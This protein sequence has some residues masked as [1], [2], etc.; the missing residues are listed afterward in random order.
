[1]KI[2]MISNSVRLRLRKSDLAELEQTRLIEDKVHFPGNHHFVFALS[3]SEDDYI[4]A[5]YNKERLLISIPN[6]TAMNWINSPDVGIE[7]QIIINDV[8]TLHIL[9]EKDFPCLDREEENKE[10]TFWELSEEEP[11]TC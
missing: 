9:I 7:K 6:I 11:K 1:M 10:D 2:R 4:D 5:S 3:I 8:N